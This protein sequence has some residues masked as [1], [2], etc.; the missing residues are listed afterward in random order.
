M[1][2]WLT[3]ASTIGI[4][5]LVSLAQSSGEPVKPVE[6]VNATGLDCWCQVSV[7]YVKDADTVKGDVWLPWDVVLVNQDIRPEGWDAWEV[8]KRRDSIEAGEIT[9]AEVVKGK[10]AKAELEELLKTGTLWVKPALRSRD[11]Y[12]RLLSHWRVVQGF[13]VIEMKQY[14]V[15][16][17]WIRGSK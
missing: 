6:A 10:K 5:A 16:H 1:R 12:G 8:S 9:D 15:E 17:K 13:K 11:P 14:A 4:I 2:R 7:S 3:F